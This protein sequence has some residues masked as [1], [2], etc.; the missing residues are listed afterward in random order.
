[1][2]H[3]WRREV[4]LRRRCDALS[5]QP[6]WWRQVG[7]GFVQ[8]VGEDAAVLVEQVKEVLWER[9]NRD[10]R[11]DHRRSSLEVEDGA[12]KAAGRRDG[13]RILIRGGGRGMSSCCS[14]RHCRGRGSGWASVR[15]RTEEGGVSW[16]ERR[17]YGGLG[18]RMAKRGRWEGVKHDLGT[19]LSKM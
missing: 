14:G 10:R 12:A 8:G 1:M 9:S 19:R 16:L 7:L 13:R 18:F 4:E 6:L 3:R 17:G 2:E 5:V 11:G 15:W